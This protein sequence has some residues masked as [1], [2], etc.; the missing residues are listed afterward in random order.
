[1]IICFKCSKETKNVLD[2]LVQR[3]GYTDYGQAI[4]TGLVNLLVLQDEVDK[5]G[6]IVISDRG[7]RP[8]KRP[9]AR[10]GTR[11]DNGLGATTGS[12]T[13][14]HKAIRI[15]DAFLPEGI[16]PH[17]PRLA[18]PSPET[19]RPDQ[20]ITIDQWTFGQHNRLLPAKASCRA[21][22][23][24]MVDEPNGIPLA[25]GTTLV[26]HWA[27][28][29]GDYLS[30]HDETNKIKKDDRLSTAFP[31]IGYESAKGLM[32]Y[33]S[34]FV[35]A[36][37]R[38]GE[39]LGLLA[40]F[41]LIGRAQTEEIR[42]L[43]TKAGWDFALLQ[44]PVLD[45]RQETPVQKFSEEENSYLLEHISCSVPAEDFAYRA[46]ITAINQGANT[47]EKLDKAMHRYI[48]RQRESDLKRSFI[49]TQRS[50]AI[51]RMAD[52]GLLTRQRHGVRVL[53]LLTR[54]GEDYPSRSQEPTEEVDRD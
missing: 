43:L 52:L 40:D 18:D 12:I 8:N 6:S 53:Y 35:A 37:N 24:L 22:A 26:A 51:S 42:I 15:P 47:P 38:K 33:A 11:S 23:H 32:R 54:L 19:R 34:Q 9:A 46:I 45:G 10:T 39:L 28:S 41:K 17:P 44:N 16:P 29:L 5:S 14:N 27:A 7:A 25:E 13:L 31:R 36:A 3:G 48:P 20:Q 1:M 50:G 21:L 2:R 4:S 49:A 30:A